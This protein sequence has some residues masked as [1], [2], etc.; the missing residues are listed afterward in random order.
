MFLGS[1]FVLV[2]LVWS[3]NIIF[4]NYRPVTGLPLVILTVLTYFGGI[5][6]GIIMCVSAVG[7][8]Q[9]YLA[10]ASER[11]EVT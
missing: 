6:S 4:I 1:V 8:G 2:F 5:F 11:A 3:T 9:Y 7:F 10:R